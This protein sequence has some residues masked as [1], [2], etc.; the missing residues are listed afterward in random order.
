[1]DQLVIGIES[2]DPESVSTVDIGTRHIEHRVD[3]AAIELLSSVGPVFCE[4][5]ANLQSDP[6]LFKVTKDS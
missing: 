1:M 5:V 3:R 4:V 6:R 2:A